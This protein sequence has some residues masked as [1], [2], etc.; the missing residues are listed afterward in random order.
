MRLRTMPEG[1]AHCAACSLSCRKL[2]LLFCT[3]RKPALARIVRKKLNT[4]GP[5]HLPHTNNC[6][7][8]VLTNTYPGGFR[9]TCIISELPESIGPNRPT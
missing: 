7:A 8:W 2:V 1:Q 5:R 9:Q 6:A 3:V 4:M